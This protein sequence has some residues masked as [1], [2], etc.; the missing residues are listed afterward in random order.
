MSK[1]PLPEI[2]EN[3]EKDGILKFTLSNTNVSIV[4]ALRRTIHAD[5]KTLAFDTTDDSNITI[6][7]NTT[8]F[9]NDIL[10]QR[11]GCIPVYIKDITQNMDN[12]VMELKETNDTDIMRYITT[13]H[14]K[15]KNKENGKYLSDKDRNKI[16][17]PTVLKNKNISKAEEESYWTIFTRLMP[18]VTSEIPGQEIHLECKFSVKSAKDNGMF[19]VAC[20]CGYG[21]TEDKVKQREVWKEVEDKYKKE[22]MEAGDIEYK[23]QNWYNHDAKRIFKANSFDFIL[24]SVGVFSNAELM[25]DAVDIIVNKLNGI[26]AKIEADSIEIKSSDNTINDCYDIILENHDYTIGKVIEYV[27]HYQYLDT[28]KAQLSYAGFIKKHPHDSYSIVR[29]A[30]KNNHANENEEVNMK[31]ALILVQNACK[32]GIGVFNEIGENFNPNKHEKHEKHE[33]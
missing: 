32:I 33:K 20:T 23:K 12:L 22:G 9:N 17:P 1:I 26:R 4:N 13:E 27:L 14:F 30:F 2:K 24:E 5:L 8:K 16:F 11:L 7:R 28:K 31:N 15:I 6:Y 21:N 10:K 29:L 18:K 3:N 25:S 19:N